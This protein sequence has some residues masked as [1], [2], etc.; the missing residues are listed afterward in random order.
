MSFGAIIDTFGI[1]QG[2]ETDNS[3][4]PGV[5]DSSVIG[6]RTI[7]T[8]M[9][10]GSGSTSLEIAGGFFLGNN[11]SLAQGTSAAYYTGLW[12]LTSAYATGLA[13]EV[14]SLENYTGGSITF[15][16][17]DTSN[18][19][20]TYTMGVPS[21]G[22]IAADLISFANIGNVD[23]A[24]IDTIGFVFTHVQAQDIVLDNFQTTVPEPGTYA[25]MAAGLLGLFAIRRKKA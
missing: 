12:D 22:L 15:L 4:V 7:V 10:V 3:T 24:N 11:G 19:V 25:M 17:E 14:V 2:P 6:N 9:L 5:F 18:N 1:V 23:R 20:A 8:D 16:I 21:V 13:I